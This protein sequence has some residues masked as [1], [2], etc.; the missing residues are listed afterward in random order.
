MKGSDIKG[1]Y[2]LKKTAAVLLSAVLAGGVLLGCSD[3][4][5]GSSGGL[6]EEE[7]IKSLDALL[8]KVSVTELTPEYDISDTGEVSSLA[9]ELPDISTYD[10][11]VKGSGEIDVEIFAS[12]EKS[13]PKSDTNKYD[14][15]L[16]EAAEA[17]NDEGYTAGGKSVSVSVR[18]IASGPATDYIVSGKY[19]PD[20]FS[21]ANELW[22]EMVAAKDVEIEML[23][24]KL[25]GNT[26]GLLLT[27]KRYNELTE[28]YGEVT[29][30]KV[31]E[32][33]L[34]GDLL[35]GY[36]NPYVSST[37]LNILTAMLQTF[38]SS[39]PL[40]N[41]ALSRLEEFQA[42]IPPVSYTTAQMRETAAKGLLDAMVMEYQAYIN[43]S[44]LKSYKFIPIG[45]RHD[46]PLY[47]I[48]DVSAEKREA[49]TS[50]AKFCKSDEMQKKATDM[51]FNGNP[52]YESAELL[53]SGAELFSA[54]DAWKEKK[55]AG[56]PVMAVFV[57]DVS[58]SMDGTPIVELKTSLLNASQYIGETS[59]VGLVSYSHEVYINLPIGEFNNQQR[60]AFNGSVKNLSANGGTATYDAV[61]VAQRML[62]DKKEELPNAKMMI[63]VLSDGEQTDGYNLSK[64]SP[65][66]EGLKIPIHTICYGTSIDEMEEMSTINEA[67]SIKASPEDVVYNLKNIFNAQM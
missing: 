13:T 41:T 21:P 55:D 42:K 22:G 15:W 45:V 31:V 28:K 49:L 37:G 52:D 65:V 2:I 40:S 51:G 54:Q 27:E 34:G 7:A 62:L 16:L 50:F 29:L 17:F 32:A 57:T 39:N 59:Y 24:E 5:S 47:A 46:N 23:E 1:K 64:I 58:G 48:G 4:R 30:G 3:G 8:T 10:L 67:S 18:T 44:E 53:L 6:S 12:T 61:L 66:V 25:T 14:G 56:Q 36:T 20:A 9:D 33:V 43:Q 35:L 38:D 11:S 60:A 26:A 63:F 19:L